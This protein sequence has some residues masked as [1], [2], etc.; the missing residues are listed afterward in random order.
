[1]PLLAPRLIS[2]PTV[3]A[4][5]PGLPLS[6]S[7]VALMPDVASHAAVFAAAAGA[8]YMLNPCGVCSAGSLK[9]ISTAAQRGR[10][11]APHQYGAQARGRP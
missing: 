8:T 2:L 3:Q 6:A 4:S 7:M 5:S 11:G 10:G 1:M 9:P